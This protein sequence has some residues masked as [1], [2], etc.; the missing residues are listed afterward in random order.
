MTQDTKKAVEFLTAASDANDRSA[1]K[2]LAQLYEEGRGVK[3][4]KKKAKKLYA[5]S[6][7]VSVG[8]CFAEIWG[9]W[10]LG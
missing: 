8:G 6:G 3:M 1:Q 4:N 7:T 2:L 5:K 9:F 10:L